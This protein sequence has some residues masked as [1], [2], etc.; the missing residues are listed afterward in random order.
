MP[1]ASSSQNDARALLGKRLRSLRDEAGLSNAHLSERC[2]WSIAKTSRIEH[3]KQAASRTDIIA[4]CTATD[5]PDQAEDLLTMSQAAEDLYQLYRTARGLAELQRKTLASY[6]GMRHYRA[7]CIAIIPG[8]LQTRAYVTALFSIV[9][10]FRNWPDATSE[11]SISGRMIRQEL[12]HDPRRRF[13]FVLDEGLLWR[14]IGG[15]EVMR[16]QLDALSEASCLPQ[17]TLGIMSFARPFDGDASPHESFYLFDSTRVV[18]E[19]VSAEIVI[20]DPAEVRL[21]ERAFASYARQAVYGDKA[22]ELIS[23]A[24]AALVSE[25]GV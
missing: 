22:R 7:Y 17:V 12:L 18:Q 2:G 24:R 20:T 23:R 1:S 11:A 8:F 19:T 25:E 3:G 5:R 9:G 10:R 15:P 16:E 13:L 6:D 14:Q 4:W 21:Y